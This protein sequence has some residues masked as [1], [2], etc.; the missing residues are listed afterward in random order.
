MKEAVRIER[1]L[2]IRQ[3]LLTSIQRQ[4]NKKTRVYTFVRFAAKKG[5]SPLIALRSDVDFVKKLGI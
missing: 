3:A 1:Q 4:D 5:T 2:K